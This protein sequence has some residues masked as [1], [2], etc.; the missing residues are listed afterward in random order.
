LAD[1]GLRRFIWLVDVLYDRRLCLMLTSEQAIE[2]MLR[3]VTH[4]VDTHRVLSRLAEM[5]SAAYFTSSP[6]KTQPLC[7]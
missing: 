5:R 4:S 3:Q 2:S 6:L 7:L 1:D